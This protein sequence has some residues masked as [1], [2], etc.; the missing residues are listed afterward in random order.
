MPFMVEADVVNLGGADTFVPEPIWQRTS[1]M[2]RPKFTGLQ[3]VAIRLVRDTIR[4]ASAAIASIPNCYCLGRPL[5]ALAPPPARLL[6]RLAERSW[7]PLNH[8]IQKLQKGGIASNTQQ[9]RTNRPGKDS[10]WNPAVI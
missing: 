4:L 3:N 10:P 7:E 5:P 6:S 8:F 9:S 1:A 2:C